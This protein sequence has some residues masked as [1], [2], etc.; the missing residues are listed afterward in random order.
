MDVSEFSAIQAFPEAPVPFGAAFAFFAASARRFFHTS[1]I[2]KLNAFLSATVFDPIFAEVTGALGLRAFF[3]ACA[4]LLAAQIFF[5]RCDA[6]L[7]SAGVLDLLAAGGIDLPCRAG[8]P[9]I[10]NSD[11]IFS[12]SA[13]IPAFC[14][15]NSSN[16]NSNMR[17]RFISP[18]LKHEKDHRFSSSERRL[19]EGYSNWQ[20]RS[21]IR[22]ESSGV[23][24]MICQ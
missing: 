24:L 9:A 15:F 13:S 8:D 23:V 12:I 19:Y 17:F 3:D 4:L 20:A 11:R 10:R 14:F 1:F 22:S 7:R 6:A 5:I 21:V 18:F 2:F 16:A